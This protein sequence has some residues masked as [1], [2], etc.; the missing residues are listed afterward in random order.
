MGAGRAAGLAAAGVAVALSLVACDSG[1]NANSS[2]PDSSDIS[3]C[4]TLDWSL[5]STDTLSDEERKHACEAIGSDPVF[6]PLLGSGQA[7]RYD[8]AS[9]YSGSNEKMG[10]VVSLLFDEPVDLPAGIPE[11][12]TVTRPGVEGSETVLDD[13]GLPELQA[14][15]ELT[16]VPAALVFVRLP[17]GEVFA[18]TP[19]SRSGVSM[20]FKPPLSDG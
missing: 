17:E 20:S 5:P 12:V 14:Q 15:S 4:A 11:F 1:G 3:A 2:P 8:F 19:T 9:W 18:A 7:E 16:D 13:Q 10:V 6:G